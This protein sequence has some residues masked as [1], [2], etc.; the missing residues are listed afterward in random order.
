MGL[1]ALVQ[2]RNNARVAVAGSVDLFSDAAFAATATDRAGKRCAVARLAGWPT[3]QRAGAGS[4]EALPPPRCCPHAAVLLHTHTTPLPRC[5]QPGPRGQ[6]GVCHRGQQV[7]VPGAGRA[8]RRQPDAPCGVRGAPGGGGAGTV[9]RERRGGDGVVG[10]A[11]VEGR[12][13]WEARKD[14]VPPACSQRETPRPL[15]WA[16]FHL[17][18]PSRPTG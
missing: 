17:L 3:R 1:V 6:R 18:P 9:S 13:L 10:G 16:M 11:A 7:G 2:L 8:A 14:G 12:A 15:N 5:P 4:M